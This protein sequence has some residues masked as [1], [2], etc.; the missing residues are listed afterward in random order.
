M[1][2]AVCVKEIVI[3]DAVLDHICRTCTKRLSMGEFRR[4]ENKDKYVCRLADNKLY[5]DLNTKQ[6]AQRTGPMYRR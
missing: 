4:P 5:P 2:C 3:A 6:V 1:K